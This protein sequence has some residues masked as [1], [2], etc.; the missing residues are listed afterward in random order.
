VGRPQTVYSA[1]D[2]EA[3]EGRDYRLFADMVA[4]QITGARQRARSIGSAR[5]W[6]AYLVGRSAPPPGGRSSSGPNLAVL[7]VALAEAGFDPRFRRRGRGRVDI[8]LRDCP[9]R[10]L[11]D[12][13][14]ELVCALHRGLLEGM[15]QG[16]RPTMRLETFEPLAER[17]A[18]CR[19][20][21][22]PE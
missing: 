11:L 14:R 6:G 2:R 4:G 10:E 3:R 1:V 22:V 18:V 15:L 7:Q 16:S 17:T 20:T 12:E 13:H 19:L 5:A 21:A 8:A 9:F